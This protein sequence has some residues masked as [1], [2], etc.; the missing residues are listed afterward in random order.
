MAI[1]LLGLG[2][3]EPGAGIPE[4]TRDV[5]AEG[6]S[7]RGGGG[8]GAAS[9]DEP[10]IAGLPGRGRAERAGDAGRPNLPPTE[11][12]P[13]RG[14]PPGR[15]NPERGRAEAGASESAM[16]LGPETRRI[17]SSS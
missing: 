4:P 17:R 15:D 2:N 9:L 16:W 14:I 13:G 12:L 10:T 8:I 5:C 3:A 11:G 6:E 1:L 7:G